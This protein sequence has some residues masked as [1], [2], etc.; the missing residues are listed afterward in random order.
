VRCQNRWPQCGETAI[1]WVK[2]AT[3]T[4]PMC[5]GCKRK[6]LS[7]LWGMHPTAEPLADL[8]CRNCEDGKVYSI[9]GQD[10]CPVCLGSGTLS[11]TPTAPP[12]P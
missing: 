9:M 7:E 12:P 11:D 3:E 8:A 4:M 1:W 10:R 2:H 5:D 6:L